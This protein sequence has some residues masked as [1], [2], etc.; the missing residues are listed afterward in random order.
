MQNPEAK[1]AYSKDEAA[2]RLG[3]GYVTLH[4]KLLKTGLLRTVR[5]GTRVLIPRSELERFL[6]PPDQAA[7]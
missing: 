2:Q 7:A 3:I 4:N 5:V 6:T 1:D